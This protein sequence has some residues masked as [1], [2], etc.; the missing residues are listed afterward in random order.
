MQQLLAGFA[1]TLAESFLA[2]R[3]KSLVSTV[4]YFSRRFRSLKHLVYRR[5]EGSIVAREGSEKKLSVN[6]NECNDDDGA[7]FT[8]RLLK[9][10]FP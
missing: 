4:W 10:H 7:L 9:N 1:S 6:E 2:F 5:L 8:N 3:L